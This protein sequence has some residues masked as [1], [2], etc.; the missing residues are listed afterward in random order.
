METHFKTIGDLQ[1]HLET[2]NIDQAKQILIYTEIGY[3]IK[4][5]PPKENR[6]HN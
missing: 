6:I 3:F 2:T 1:N 4:K 5:K